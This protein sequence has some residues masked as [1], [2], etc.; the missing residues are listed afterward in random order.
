M[1]IPLLSDHRQ[2]NRSE[3]DLSFLPTATPA[4]LYAFVGVIVALV[5]VFMIVAGVT[6]YCYYRRNK[7]VIKVGSSE[8][9]LWHNEYVANRHA[10]SWK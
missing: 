4:Y 2:L 5:V 10:H 6:V 1:L 9:S 3:Y 8:G 7:V